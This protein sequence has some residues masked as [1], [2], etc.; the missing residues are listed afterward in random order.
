MQLANACKHGGAARQDHVAVQVLADNDIALHDGLEGGVMDAAGLL[1]YEAWLEQ[2]PR[3]SET[4]VSHGDDVAIWQLIGLLLVRPLR[5]LLH[6]SVKV[7][8]D[9]AQLLIH[10]GDHLVLSGRG[11]STLNCHDMV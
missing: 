2:H 10:I 7:Q 9:V 5:D 8:D 3:A 6:L 11:A 1:A 4:L